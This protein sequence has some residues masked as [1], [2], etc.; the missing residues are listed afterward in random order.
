MDDP[1]FQTHS[2]NDTV[3][4]AE[5]ASITSIAFLDLLSAKIPK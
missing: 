2:H 1:I 5:I 3:P 4:P